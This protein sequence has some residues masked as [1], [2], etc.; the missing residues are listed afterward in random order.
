MTAHMVAAVF[1]DWYTEVVTVR[2]GAR[3][4]IVGATGMWTWVCGRVAE[5][6]LWPGADLL[7]T[8]VGLM[9]AHVLVTVFA[10]RYTEVVSVGTGAS[11][12]IVRTA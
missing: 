10:S 4:H 11:E 5:W 3:L 7:V 12:H 8:A 9:T 6:A 1:P 2:A